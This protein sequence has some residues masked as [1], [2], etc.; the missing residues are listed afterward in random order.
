IRS[1]AFKHIQPSHSS[2]SA[3]P[4]AV[5]PPRKTPAGKLSSASL[6]GYDDCSSVF[7]VPMKLPASLLGAL[8]LALTAVGLSGCAQE[9]PAPPP[10]SYSGEPNE[11]SN[12]AVGGGGEGEGCPVGGVHAPCPA[13]GRG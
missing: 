12:P 10:G 3:A 8:A 13:C 4:W 11:G 1:P 7:E 5:R 6:V 2:L 9:K